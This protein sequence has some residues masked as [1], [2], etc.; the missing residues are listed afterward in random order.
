MGRVGLLSPLLCS[1][2]YEW[3]GRTENRYVAPVLTGIESASLLPSG[4]TTTTLLPWASKSTGASN[5][6]NVSKPR[7][8]SFIVLQIASLW[9][10]ERYPQQIKWSGWEK[11]YQLFLLC[12][13]E[14]PDS[15]RLCH[16]G[17]ACSVRVQNLSG[18]P[19]FMQPLRETTYH[20]RREG[21][22]A[23]SDNVEVSQYPAKA[24]RALQAHSRDGCSTMS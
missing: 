5:R 4:T 17:T 19:R 16:C 6:N 23:I 2:E 24:V 1:I 10:L 7:T 3:P 20:V 21:S 8:V 22:V 14:L 15:E 11:R 18:L 12:E 13:T 9:L